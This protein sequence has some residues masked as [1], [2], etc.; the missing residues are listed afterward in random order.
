[1]PSLCDCTNERVRRVPT[2]YCVYTLLLARSSLAKPSMSAGLRTRFVGPV[3]RTTGISASLFM[4]TSSILALWYRPAQGP[5]VIRVFH[6]VPC[7]MTASMKLLPLSS[8]AY[9]F[10]VGATTGWLTRDV[11][12]ADASCVC[13]RVLSDIGEVSMLPTN[14]SSETRDSVG[15]LPHKTGTT[16]D[17]NKFSA[18]KMQSREQIAIVGSTLLA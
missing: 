16:R 2:R 11:E 4:Q 7:F 5:K 10:V 9:L 12:T 18:P 8:S 17:A 14:S 1:M 15:R 3:E 13:H 6:E